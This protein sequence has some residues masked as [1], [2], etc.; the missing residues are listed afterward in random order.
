MFSYPAV[1]ALL[2]FCCVRI[3]QESPAYAQDASGNYVGFK[4]CSS[5]HQTLTEGWLTTRHARTF[6]SLKKSSQ[7]N[8][9]G[10]VKC[11]VTGY[12]ED[13]GFI[14]YDLTPEMAGVQCEQCHGAGRKHVETGGEVGLP[15]R[16]MGQAACRR[17]HTPGQDANFDYQKKVRSVHG[18]QVL[19]K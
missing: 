10:C 15:V 16:S 7:E 11:H 6:E 12:G 13:G 14:D 19:N 4:A 17:C 9:P 2:I 8:L 3:G 1:M 5:C 18:S